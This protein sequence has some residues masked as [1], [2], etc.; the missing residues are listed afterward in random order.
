ME[1][2]KLQVTRISMYSKMFN[3]KDLKPP[4]TSPWK[5]SSVITFDFFMCYVPI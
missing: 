1:Y 5:M 2:T 3:W 4:S